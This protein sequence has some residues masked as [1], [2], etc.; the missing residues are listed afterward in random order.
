MVST[1]KYNASIEQ[2][3]NA[4]ELALQIPI[5][6]FRDGYGFCGRDG[7]HVDKDSFLKYN[8]LQT[9]NGKK[10]TLP[11]VGFLT[12]PFQGAGQACVKKEPRLEFE[13]SYAPKSTLPSGTRNRI[14]PLVGC[15][16]N[17]IQKEEHIVTETVQPDWLR[18]GY[19][20]RRCKYSRA[21]P[22]KPINSSHW[23][24]PSQS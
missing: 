11:Q 12:V 9:Q 17:N 20:S 2:H 23:P 24:Y 21:N 15:I 18:G 22:P 3:K 10:I 1:L 7:V 14:V 4:T 19:P 16:A 13:Y 6:N 5:A 8:S